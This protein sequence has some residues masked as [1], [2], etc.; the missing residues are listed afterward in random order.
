MLCSVIDFAWQDNA[1]G[2]AVAGPGLIL[3]RAAVPF[4]DASGNRKA[5]ASAGFLRAE[6]RIEQALLDLGRNAFASVAHFKNH[7]VVFAPSNRSACRARAKRDRPEAI[8]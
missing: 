2:R 1:E 5:E 7:G 3:E 4:N 6:E 8:N